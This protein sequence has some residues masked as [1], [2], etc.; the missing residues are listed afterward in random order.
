MSRK[1]RVLLAR[2]S[3]TIP[4]CKAVHCYLQPLS[5]QTK[6]VQ[7]YFGLFQVRSYLFGYSPIFTTYLC[8][9]RVTDMRTIVRALLPTTIDIL[10]TVCLCT[11]FFHTSFSLA[12]A[13][14]CGRAQSLYVEYSRID[15]HGAWHLAVGH[16]A[17]KSQSYLIILST[18]V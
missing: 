8:E 7:D 1:A 15:H 2:D 6:K 16:G 9:S 3:H 17:W 18:A 12:R 14:G 5:P 13:R 10:F 11:S 4:S